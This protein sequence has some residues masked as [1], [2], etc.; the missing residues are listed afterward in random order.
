[1]SSR[2]R[3]LR[4]LRTRYVLAALILAGCA[5]SMQNTPQQDYTYEMAQGCSNIPNAHLE[6]VEPD[7]RY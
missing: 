6:R 3:H 1:M 5:S 2:W 4:V 7:G